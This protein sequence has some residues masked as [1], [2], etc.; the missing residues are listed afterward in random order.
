MLNFFRITV[1]NRI[2]HNEIVLSAVTSKYNFKSGEQHHSERCSLA[3]S[4]RPKLLDQFS[5]QIHPNRLTMPGPH[6]WSGPI[7]GKFDDGRSPWQ[8]CSPKIE[9]WF[10]AFVLDQFSLPHR[11]VRVL[12]L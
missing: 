6:G 2:A 11:V 1:G 12:N 9:G 10:R 5:F 3:R 7:N 8:V 4:D